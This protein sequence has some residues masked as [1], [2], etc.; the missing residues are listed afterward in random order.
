M[1]FEGLIGNEKNKNILANSVKTENILHS[2]L[3]TGIK[4]IGKSLFAEEF[5][6]MIL[7]DSNQEKPC[8][9]CKSCLEFQG[10]SH[11]D[12][13]VVKPIE[14][15]TIKIEQ[16][17][18]LQEKI[19]EKPV[20]SEKKVY[21]IDEADTMTREASN[22]LL[23]TLEEPPTYATL[24]LITDNE[25][26]LLVTIK[27]RC[28]KIAF[29][30]LTGEE[31]KIYLSQV[32][33]RDNITDKILKQSQGSIGRLIEIQENIETYKQL[34]EIIENLEKNDI[35]EIWK[36]SQVL[37]QAKENIIELLDYMNIL[38]FEKF[39]ENKYTKY[40][41]AIPIIEDTKK[42]ILANSN[43]DMSIDNLLL[44]LKEEL[45]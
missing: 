37:Y 45:S 3:F 32:D 2:Y 9:K 13:L 1:A 6:K 41:K 25:S 4:G 34:D 30:P 23:K 24:I 5:A 36:Q 33:F 39:K 31:L 16:I 11:P 14:G 15:K 28:T 29:E 10:R 20:T 42:R 27:S 7:C 22:A 26:K 18:Y 38:F 12:F 8:G 43:Y 19:A 35:T 17:R 40:T 44:R 21:I